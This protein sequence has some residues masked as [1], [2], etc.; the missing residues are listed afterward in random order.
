MRK[1]IEKREQKGKK[2]KRGAMSEQKS[3]QGT[4]KPIGFK[5]KFNSEVYNFV[6]SIVS[7]SFIAKQKK[8][9]EFARA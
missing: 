1:K 3:E 7:K 9:E 8:P 2:G 4:T 5:N 6:I